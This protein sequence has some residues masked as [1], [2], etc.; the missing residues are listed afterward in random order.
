MTHH[1]DILRADYT[2]STQRSAIPCLLNA[3]AKGLLGFRKEIEGHVL[4]TLVPGL[5][6]MQNAVVLLARMDE[7]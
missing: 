6:R 2:D 3:Y 1:V 5:E 4:K 7:A